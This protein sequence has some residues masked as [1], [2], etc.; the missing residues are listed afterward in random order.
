MWRQVFSQKE[1]YD[2]IYSLTDDTLK[3][4]FYELTYVSWMIEKL[5]ISS[6][7]IILDV[8][9]GLGKVLTFI[10]YLKGCCGVGV[11][12]SVKGLKKAYT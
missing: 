10:C 6:K 1:I 12:I 4:S 7:S 2:T 9:C 3:M 8:G 5:E 11:D